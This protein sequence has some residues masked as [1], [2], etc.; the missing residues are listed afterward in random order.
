MYD[1]AM[2]GTEGTHTELSQRFWPGFHSKVRA[3]FMVFTRFILQLQCDHC[4]R[5]HIFLT[6]D[7]VNE[8]FQCVF[9]KG[10]LSS[11]EE[12]TKTLQFPY[13]GFLER[14]QFDLR[15]CQ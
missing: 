11:F 4:G 6:M 2:L 14:V 12:V 8:A 10:I 3:S 15:L 7:V 1:I 5:K 9:V 13:L